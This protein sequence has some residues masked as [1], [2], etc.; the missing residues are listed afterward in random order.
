MPL[1][2]YCKGASDL[3]PW[4][5]CVCRADLCCVCW[6]ARIHAGLA[7]QHLCA[8]RCHLLLRRDHVLTFL[9]CSSTG[10][11][12]RANVMVGLTS[13]TLGGTQLWLTLEMLRDVT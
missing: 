12:V 5:V 4:S 11:C 2:H 8:A 1:V 3:F 9:S 7:K 13:I 6:T 10:S